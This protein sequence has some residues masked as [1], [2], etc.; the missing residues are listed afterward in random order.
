MASIL[1]GKG[2]VVAEAVVNMVAVTANTESVTVVAS[3]VGRNGN[4]GGDVGCHGG[5]HGGGG[6]VVVAKLQGVEGM[7]WLVWG[8]DSAGRE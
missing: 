8:G 6:T 4:G 2:P 3:V 1:D 7:G 5:G